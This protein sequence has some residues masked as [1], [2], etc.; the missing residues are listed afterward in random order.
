M[1]AVSLTCVLILML[2]T[3][4]V[5][6]SASAQTVLSAS[7]SGQTPPAGPPPADD[8]STARSLVQVTGCGKYHPS[9][10]PMV[11]ALLI[12]YNRNYR[13]IARTTTGA[14]GCGTVRIGQGSTIYLQVYKVLGNPP[15]CWITSPDAYDGYTGWLR[16]TTST[17]TV[18]GYPKE[19]C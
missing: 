3:L 13:E 9:G 7:A 4:A 19:L 16:A 11:G 17:R 15:Q 14:N 1:K 5:V 6:P 2:I 10:A 12:A 8:S 18:W